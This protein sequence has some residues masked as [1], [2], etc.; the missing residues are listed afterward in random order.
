MT[1]ESLFSLDIP[2]CNPDIERCPEKCKDISRGAEHYCEVCST[3]QNYCNGKTS[4]TAPSAKSQEGILKLHSSIS[5]Y[6]TGPLS[7]LACFLSW[8]TSLRVF[9]VQ[10]LIASLAMSQEAKMLTT[11]LPTLLTLPSQSPAL[12]FSITSSSFLPVRVKFNVSW[13]SK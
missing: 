13:N 11:S 9:S 5:C 4:P 2:Q 12:D 3:V 1:S 8:V 10:L 7:D 6:S